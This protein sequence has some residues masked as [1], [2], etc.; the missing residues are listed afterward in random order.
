MNPHKPR[1]RLPAGFRFLEAIH[2]TNGEGPARTVRQHFDDLQQP[3][4]QL[5]HQ[6]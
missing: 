2:Q 1:G 6:A 3:L 4:D 5:S